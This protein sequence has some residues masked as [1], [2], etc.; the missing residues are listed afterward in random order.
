MSGPQDNPTPAE[1]REAAE[2]E[3]AEWLLERLTQPQD[4]GWGPEVAELLKGA[5]QE[6]AQKSD[7]Q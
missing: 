3:H 4:G 1:A 5:F 7:R 6:E 2:A